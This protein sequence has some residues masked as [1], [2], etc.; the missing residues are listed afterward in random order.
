MYLYNM[1][2]CIVCRL[3]RNVVYIVYVQRTHRLNAFG[4]LRQFC[5]QPETF[6]MKKSE[7]DAGVL[8]KVGRMGATRR[9]RRRI[10]A[11]QLHGADSARIKTRLPHATSC[12]YC[13][14][15]PLAGLRR[16]CDGI[17]ERDKIFEYYYAGCMNVAES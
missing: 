1:W 8:K 3:Q 12:L 4:I 11:R 14:P 13:S 17:C 16:I 10:L 5:R 7:T 6:A 9:H 2:I 15:S